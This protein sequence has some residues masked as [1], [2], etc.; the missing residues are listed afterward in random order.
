MSNPPS[1]GSGQGGNKTIG[2]HQ[3]PILNVE[4]MM[5]QKE[6]NINNEGGNVSE[7]PQLIHKQL[8]RTTEVEAGL[9]HSR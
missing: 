2:K 1:R 8:A 9:A 6:N 3:V 4:E 5:E 7:R